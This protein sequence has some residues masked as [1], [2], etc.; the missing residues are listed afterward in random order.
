MTFK[1]YSESK[2]TLIKDHLLQYLKSKKEEDLPPIFK[3]QRLIDSLEDFALRG[4]LIRGTLFLLASEMLGGKI[5]KELM[6]I[7]CGIELMHSSL[8]IQDDVIDRDRT[9][10][11][12]KTI[13]AKYE[14]D[15]ETIGAYDPYHYGVSTAIVLADVAFFFAVDL[16]SNYNNPSLSRLLKYYSHEIYLVALA[17][18]AD[19]IF[20][21]TTKEPE[22]DEIYAV[23]K[24]KT[25]RYTFSLPFEMAAILLNVSEKT[26][27]TL[28]QLG[29]SAGIIFQLKDDE[30]GLFGEEEVIG[31]PV[32]SDVRE[33]KKTLIRFL[34]YQKAVG[35]DREILDK[36]FGNP[37]SG[38]AEIDVVKKLY[39]KYSIDEVIKK[40]VEEIM[41]VVWNLFEKIDVKNEYKN[42]LKSL[43]EFN[44]QRKA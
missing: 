27:T 8:L 37:K 13:F 10:R 38:K 24:H 18:S 36:Y 7:A 32:G 42:V 29:E 39:E 19:S 4:K 23:Y 5:T 17:E 21:Q 26:R 16:I 3:E 14:K 2:R 9:R 30:I 35:Q 20:G 41:R 15:G 25:A 44:L 33:N 40:E 12:A 31:K 34:L 43:L 22:R 1:T 11:G 28:A 6:D